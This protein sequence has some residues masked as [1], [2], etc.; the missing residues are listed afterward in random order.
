MTTATRR[1]DVVEE[2][3]PDAPV[4]IRVVAPSSLRE[5]YTMDV[6]Y[7]DEPYTIVIPRGGVKEGEEFESMIDPKQKYTSVLVKLQPS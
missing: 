2:E 7:D 1:D 4:I 3:D 5:G 6:L